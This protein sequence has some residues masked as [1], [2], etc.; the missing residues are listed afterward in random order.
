[1]NDLSCNN[2]F[3]FA[4]HELSQIPL[5]V[6][7]HRLLSIVDKIARLGFIASGA[8]RNFLRKHELLESLKLV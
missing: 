1:M 4:I 5:L 3:L 2:F 8:Y 7:G 6:E